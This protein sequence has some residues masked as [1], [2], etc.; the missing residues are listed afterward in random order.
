MPM[1]RPQL[2]EYNSR[3]GVQAARVSS[4]GSGRE[5]ESGPHRLESFWVAFE[6]TSQGDLSVKRVASRVIGIWRARLDWHRQA[7]AGSSKL[8]APDKH[9]PAE[10]EGEVPLPRRSA[11][12]GRGLAL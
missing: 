4:E 10:G 9:Q 12:V 11:K 2:A 5:G 1:E 3:H 6:L 8:W 7:C